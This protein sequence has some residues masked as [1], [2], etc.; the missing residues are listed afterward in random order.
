MRRIKLSAQTAAASGA[1]AVM[2][3]VWG[4]VCLSPQRVSQQ[5]SRKHFVLLHW[6]WETQ[7]PRLKAAV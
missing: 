4:T 5:V 7:S 3:R 6:W 2:S 1:A